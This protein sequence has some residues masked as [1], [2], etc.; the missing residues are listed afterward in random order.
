M[1]ET[2]DPHDDLL[3]LP[4]HLLQ[5]HRGLVLAPPAPPLT[6]P[7]RPELFVGGP[8]LGSVSLHATRF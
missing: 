4:T 1:V 5:Q 7:L 6:D 3:A 8:V 2:L